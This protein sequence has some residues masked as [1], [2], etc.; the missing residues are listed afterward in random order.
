MRH[1]YPDGYN[2]HYN[3]DKLQWSLGIDNYET[4]MM[5]FRNKAATDDIIDYKEAGS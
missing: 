5:D 2:K 1:I 4:P 3:T